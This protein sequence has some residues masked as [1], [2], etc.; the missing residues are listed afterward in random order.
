MALVSPGVWGEG[1][2][3]EARSLPRGYD[4]QKWIFA[5][6]FCLPQF[7]GYFSLGCAIK[8]IQSNK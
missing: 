3:V 7:L 2:K 4:W 6:T 8:Q 1:T 5:M